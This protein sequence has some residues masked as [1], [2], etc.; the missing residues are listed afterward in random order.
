M[1]ILIMLLILLI[2]AKFEDCEHSQADNAMVTVCWLHDYPWISQCLS[3][4]SAS[5]SA[6]RLHMIWFAYFTISVIFKPSCR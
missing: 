3:A 5:I 4:T 2:T 1:N 6:T